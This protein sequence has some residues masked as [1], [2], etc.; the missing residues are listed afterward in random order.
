MS[1]NRRINA[2]ELDFDK[3]KE[4]FKNYL[5]GQTKYQDYDFEGSNMSILL[6]ILS[7]NSHF[8]NLYTNFSLNEVFLDSAA[9]RESVVSIGKALGYTPRS[10]IAPKAIIDVV[11]TNVSS[12]A[13]PVLILQKGF[14][15][16]Y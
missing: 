7:Y 9:K 6:D 4:N 15:F 11:V 14:Y 16:L 5:K 12:G 1:T 8:N 3:I 10:S 2:A 13:P